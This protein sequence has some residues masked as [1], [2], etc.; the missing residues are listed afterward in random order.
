MDGVL[1][2][3]RVI[4]LAVNVVLYPVPSARRCFL[5]GQALR[6]AMQSYDEPLRVQVW[7]GPHELPALQGPCAGL[8]NKE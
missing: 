2:P 3:C 6:R 1:G 7:A 4:P 5:L 8:I